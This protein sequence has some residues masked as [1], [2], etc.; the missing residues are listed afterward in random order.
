MNQK[1][2]SN[3]RGFTLVELLAVIMIIGLLAT[4]M[5][6]NVNAART[7]AKDSAVKANINN[8]REAGELYY[9]SNN[10]S[11]AGFCV[12]NDCGSGSAD[13]QRLCAATKLQNGNTTVTC[14][15]SATAWCASSALVVGASHCA[16]SVGNAK[17]SV[18]CGAGTVC[19]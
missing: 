15:A 5:I 3:S 6:I 9:S 11:Y 1:N 13:W 12:T 17:D 4:I 2:E 19:P 18:N 10:N 8:L 16:D 14:N 7:K